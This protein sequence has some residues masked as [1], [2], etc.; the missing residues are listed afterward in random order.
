MA[1][2]NRLSLGFPTCCA[3]ALLAVS[4]AS[5]AAVERHVPSQYA[6]IHAAI[7]AAVNGDDVVIAP[8]RYTNFD[9]RHIN[10][11]GKAVTIRSANP[12]LPGIVAAT[13]I[14]CGRSSGEGDGAFLLYSGE[15][16]D[17][18]IAGLTLTNGVSG[19]GCLGASPTISNCVISDNNQGIYCCDGSPTI[20]NCT[21]VGNSN[22][23]DGGAVYLQGPGSPVIRNCMITGNSA[24]IGGAIVAISLQNLA[25][26]GC[27]FSR[28]TS[29]RSTIY[30]GS[31][32]VTLTNCI[33][34]GNTPS[35]GYE[36]IPGDGLLVIRYSDVQG[37]HAAVETPPGWSGTLDWGPGNISREPLFFD[38]DGSDNNPITWQDNDY[39][40]S[41]D[42][43]CINAGDPDGDYTGETDIDDQPRVHNGRVDMG[44]DEY[45]PNPDFDGDGDV[46]LTDFT[47]FQ[48]CFN[49]P[50]Q[51]V[52]PPPVCNVNSDMDGDGD[53]DLIDFSMFARCFAGPN[54]PPACR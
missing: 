43:P 25:I 29:T 51:P 37:G 16:P 14:D 18:V 9:D 6:T 13:V 26:E 21:I 39:H 24:D 48:A 49:G 42:S 17:T 47:V 41:R 1:Q 36:I 38:A 8:G 27:T 34:W 45:T 30:L 28:N 54:R 40:L 31:N 50:N 12:N 20:T 35:N 44:A 11:F 7:D 33:L 15:G 46:D 5:T 32:A 23:A 53:V 19:I 52:P 2:S 3:T 10:P 4:M 22:N